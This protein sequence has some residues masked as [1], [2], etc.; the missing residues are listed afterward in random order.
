MISLTI[1]RALELLI[2]PGRYFSITKF[3]KQVLSQRIEGLLIHIALKNDG[4]YA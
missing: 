3:G 2:T 1:R 4:S